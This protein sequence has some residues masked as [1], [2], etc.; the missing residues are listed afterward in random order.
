MAG[1][2]ALYVVMTRSLRSED[3]RANLFYTALGVWV[4]LTPAMPWLWTTPTAGDLVVMAVI[5]GLGLFTLY[6]V[7]RAASLAPVSIAA[8]VIWMQL[9]VT[10]VASVA[11]GASP[12]RRA[13]AG[14]LVVLAVVAYMWVREPNL[15][16]GEEAQTDD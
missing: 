14:S 1:T 8:P 2:F 5:G 9:V 13:L 15:V 10:T 16:V 7:D 12:G 11:L 4:V 3:T 6:A